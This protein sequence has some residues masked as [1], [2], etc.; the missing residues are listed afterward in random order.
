[1]AKPNFVMKRSQDKWPEIVSFDAGQSYD[2][3]TGAFILNPEATGSTVR[4]AL[5]KSIKRSRGALHRVSW[6]MGIHRSHVYRLTYQHHLWPL[7]NQTRAEA[8]RD[9]GAKQYQFIGGVNVSES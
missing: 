6:E 5:V 8:R 1:M 2:E 4:A 7:V 3:K 9:R